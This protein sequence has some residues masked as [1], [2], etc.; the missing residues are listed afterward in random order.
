M[1]WPLNTIVIL[2]F[3]LST[4]SC[5]VVSPKVKKD[6]SP[7]IMFKTLLRHSDRYMGKTVI[8]GGYI[9]KTQNLPDKTI[10][11]V[12]QT[13]LRFRDEP[14]GRDRSKG[15]F[16]LIYDGFLD[17][18]IYREK[19][20]ITTAGSVLGTLVQKIDKHSYTYLTLKSQEIY[21]WPKRVGYPQMPYFYDP[22]YRFPYHG[23]PHDWDPFYRHR[24][25]W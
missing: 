14:S 11:Y 22:F 23:H 15:R 6:A 1:C 21:L 17:P 2:L 16:A 8:L 20:R 13:P 7:P 4:V 24:Y 18:E 9:L 25:P 19:R 12:L 10:L 5:S 3:I